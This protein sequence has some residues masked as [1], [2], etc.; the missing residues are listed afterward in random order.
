MILFFFYVRVVFRREVKKREE[1][2]LGYTAEIDEDIRWGGG[3]AGEVNGLWTIILLSIRE[4][5]S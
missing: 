2:G 3:E 1:Q 5:S 4:W